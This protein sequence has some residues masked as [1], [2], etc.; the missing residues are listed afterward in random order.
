[1]RLLARNRRKVWYCLY[2]GRNPILDQDGY[3]TGETAITYSSPV[4]LM[5]NVTAASGDATQEQFGIGIRYDKVLQ[6]A[7]T[8]CPVDEHALLFVDVKPPEEF[9][10]ANVT[11]DYAVTRVSKSLN[12]TSIA[13]SRVRQD[14]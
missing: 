9:D 6:V 13:V 7:G 8:D 11:A 1:M 12:S 14:G 3:D 2:Q 4:A 5:A 10:P